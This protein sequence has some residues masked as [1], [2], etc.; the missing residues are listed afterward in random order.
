MNVLRLDSAQSHNRRD[1]D[2]VQLLV[3]LVVYVGISLIGRN[4]REI[5]YL[6]DQSIESS[7]DG[8]RLNIFIPVPNNDNA[9]ER[10][11]REE[12]FDEGLPHYQPTGT[13][14]SKKLVQ[15]AIVLTCA[16]R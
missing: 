13:Y 11:N 6:K 1:K 7:E 2:M 8:A 16:V 3:V 4:T 15:T 9:C 10:V 14:T 12:G 5:I